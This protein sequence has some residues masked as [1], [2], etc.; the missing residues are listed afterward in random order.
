MLESKDVHL[1]SAVVRS[2]QDAHLIDGPENAAST[3]GPGDFSR[4][5]E[6]FEEN[7]ISCH[8][9]EA[10]KGRFRMDTLAAALKGGGSGKPALVK[11]NADKSLIYTLITS[12]G[13]DRMPSEGAPLSKE[14]QTLVKNWIDA[15]ASWEGALAARD[16]PK[17][18][19]APNVASPFSR[20]KTVDLLQKNN[21]E[22]ASQHVDLLIENDL[23]ANGRSPGAIISDE[24]FLRRAYLDIAGR[25][26]TLEEYDRFFASGKPDRNA[27]I[28]NLMDS[29]G[30]ISSSHNYWL[31]ALRVKE[32]VAKNSFSTYDN[33]ILQSIKKNMP[34]D[35]F[36]YELV[37]VEG[38]F[39]DPEHAAAGYYFRDDQVGF[40]PEDS[41][42]NTMQLFL[43]TDIV[44]AQCHDHPYKKWTQR[45]FY[46]LL[47]FTNGTLVKGTDV[48]NGEANA[49]LKI[50]QPESTPQKNHYKGY[51]KAIHVGVYKGGAGTINLPP[52]YKYR[53]GRP[54]EQIK[55]RVP[56]GEPV[57]IDY[58]KPV[59]Q[60]KYNFIDLV[61]KD[62]HADVGSRIHFAKWITAPHNPMFTKTI[63][64]RLW[65][66]VFG[67]PLVGNNLDME[68][69]DMGDNPN[70]TAFLIEVMKLVK[71]DQKTFMKILCKTKAYQ[72]VAVEAIPGAYYHPAPVVKR[73]TA[74]Q[75]WDS[76][77]AIR[78]KDPD[79]G[80]MT[81]TL[82]ER[83]VIFYE[84]EKMNPQERVSFIMNE[85]TTVKDAYKRYDMLTGVGLS[86]K[87]YRASLMKHGRSSFLGVYGMSDRGII[88]GAIQDATIPQALHLMNDQTYVGAHSH[89]KQ[90]SY[91][92]ERL[93]NHANGS[94]DVAIKSIY[95]A[96]LTRNPTEAEKRLTASSLVKG[97]PLDQ[98]ALVWALI[99]SHEFRI[100]R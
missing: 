36:A 14:Q 24:G 16:R 95:N 81:G 49:A 39:A 64:N 28:D 97:G 9:A 50:L 7:C 76:L 90:P 4:V 8:G 31:D 56:F 78:Q 27:L 99:N 2:P 93:K 63:V 33:W 61:R 13:D 29:P 5:K 45:D 59:S 35:R 57:K 40:M 34:F 86:S 67:S 41:M 91:L 22:K 100:K 54:N 26:P 42:S 52:D 83:N 43:A 25:I 46:E 10:Q 58:T 84:M 94:V 72:R 89:K 98:E 85:K 70:A 23:K 62:G 18:I 6:I 71:Y 21:Q 44:C 37:A 32:T 65:G 80:I 3:R 88:D 19:A 30:F 20:M 12:H 51:Y 92:Q 53:D 55:A 75:I 1:T 73:L 15:G 82:T 96:I 47:A 74:E 48:N 79:R 60:N 77:L 38:R 66:R 17:K 11:G 68:E 87:E 69:D